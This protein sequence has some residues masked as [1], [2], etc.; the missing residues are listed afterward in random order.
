MAYKPNLYNKKNIANIRIP[1]L[2]GDCT[3]VVH[4]TLEQLL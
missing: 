2:L 4:T 1:M 3:V